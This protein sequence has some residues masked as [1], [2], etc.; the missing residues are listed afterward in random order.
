MSTT[1]KVIFTTILLATVIYGLLIVTILN[2][3][4]EN[5]VNQAKEA[6]KARTQLIMQTIDI[7]MQYEGHLLDIIQQS[8]SLYDPE[9]AEM[10]AVSANVLRSLLQSNPSIY[11]AWFVIDPSAYDN[12]GYYSREFIRSG[13]EIIENLNNNITEELS[14]VEKTP[15]YFEPLRSGTTY[16]DP[17]GFYDYNT[18]EGLIFTATVSLPIRSG[19]VIMGVLGVDI[20][21]DRLLASAPIYGNYDNNVMLLSDDLTILYARNSQLVKRNLADFT[22]IELDDIQ[23]ALAEKQDYFGEMTSPMTGELSLISLQCIPFESSGIHMYLYFDTPLQVLYHDINNAM[24]YVISISA[25]CLLLIVG[26]IYRNINFIFRPIREL[27]HYTEQMTQGDVLADIGKN[28]PPLLLRNNDGIN[29]NSEIAV[30]RN[31]FAKLLDKLYE[32]VQTLAEGMERERDLEIQRMAAYATSAAKGQFIANMSH[33]IRTPMNAVLGMSDLLLAENLNRRQ[34]GYVEDIKSSALE[35]LDIIDDLL[36]LSKIQAAKFELTPIHYNFYTLIDSVDSTVK[37]LLKD[38]RVTFAVKMLG[39]VPRV[40][41]GDDVRL[42]QVMLNLLSNAVKYTNEGSIIL[43]LQEESGSLQISVKDTGVGIPAEALPTLFDPFEQASSHYGRYHVGTGLG[44]SITRELVELM[45]GTISV[46]SKLGEGTVFTIDIP[47]VP[48]DEAQ[49]RRI[50]EEESVI[51]APDAKVLAVDDR[52]LNLNVICDLLGLSQIKAD[53]ALS[54]RQAIEMATAKSYDLIFMD[55]M[56]PDMDG[57]ETLL[58][59]RSLG[60]TVPVIALTANAISG[61]REMM[62]NVGMNGFLAKPIIRAELNQILKDWLPAAKIIPSGQDKGV[63]NAT[64][65]GVNDIWEKIKGIEGLSAEVGMELVSGQWEVYQKSLRLMLQEMDT[66]LRSLPCFLAAADLRGFSIEVHGLKGSLANIGFTALTALAYNLEKAAAGEDADYCREHL[67]PFL[68]QLQELR[69]R[70]QE[71]LLTEEA[72]SLELSAVPAALQPVL[73]AMITALESSDIL[74]INEAVEQLDSNQLFGEWREKAEQLQDF[75]MVM[76]YDK[77]LA[78][79]RSLQEGN[80][81]LQG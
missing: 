81:G 21:Y 11:C 40:L 23:V 52:E 75:I 3:L 77:A 67:P 25:V 73:A 46:E 2:T 79:A 56:M 65:V 78:V 28:L 48:G 6:Y 66:S 8:I 59:M 55:H 9:N 37:Y 41:F 71:A 76:E 50:D 38:Q 60:I 70:L 29:A 24:V 61:V 35:L 19:E 44:L 69:H 18:G 47:L 57:A 34:Y 15:W 45:G 32:S 62:L 42:R 10:A 63:V 26:L 17:G 43:C 72:P 14:A 31:A 54:G 80:T 39:E 22:V 68:E 53:M 1:R 36:D 13:D 33:E 49:I 5:S 20:L 16:F 27:I 7:T 64:L 30:L 58:E 51:L 12:R 4:R 74:A